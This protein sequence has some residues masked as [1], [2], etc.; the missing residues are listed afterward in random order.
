MTMVES[1]LPEVC[2]ACHGSAGHL[3]DWA[4]SGLGDS[5]FN[6][7]AHLYSCSTCG[8]VYVSNIDDARLSRFYADECGYFDKPHFDVGSSANL[9]KYAAYRNFIVSQGMGTAKIADVGCGRGGFLNWLK[10][11]GWPSECCG[12]DIDAKSI[13]QAASGA[14]FKRGQAL[15][16]PFADDTPRLL[17]YFHA[18]EHIRDIDRVL[19]EAARVLEAGGHLLIEV[20]DA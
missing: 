8:L 16:L 15:D 12:V 11:E 10:P 19:S 3:T 5:I 7:V 17:R 1:H 6:Y 18:M 4:F 2:P 20:P 14:H 13:P 9:A